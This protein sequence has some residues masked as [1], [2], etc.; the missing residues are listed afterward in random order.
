MTGEE[1]AVHLAHHT[2]T[3][4]RIEGKVDK[5]NGRVTALEKWIERGKGAWF[6]SSIAGPVITALVVK[7]F[8]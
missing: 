5:T 2:E 6:V 1:M 3:L 7:Y 4:A 8:A